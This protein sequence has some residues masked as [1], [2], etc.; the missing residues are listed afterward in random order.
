M[1]F[2][3]EIKFYVQEVSIRQFQMKTSNIASDARQTLLW[4]NWKKEMKWEREICFWLIEEGVKDLK[5][6]LALQKAT[7]ETN[8]PLQ[9]HHLQDASIPCEIS[10]TQ[11]YQSREGFFFGEW[12]FSEGFIQ[13]NIVHVFAFVGK[14][15]LRFTQK[16][17]LHP[18]EYEIETVS[19]RIVGFA[20]RETRTRFFSRKIAGTQR[21]ASENLS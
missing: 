8:S 20:T 3:C 15:C 14:Y 4:S 18:K 5:R 12:E 16:K 1:E 17:L 2:V 13:R 11:K 19:K 9:F 21:C 6:L 10:T 7:K